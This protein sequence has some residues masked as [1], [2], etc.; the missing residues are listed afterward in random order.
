MS[1]PECAT[2][3]TGDAP[4]LERMRFFP[5]QLITSDDL[6]QEQNYQRARMRR[7]NR[8]LHGWGVVCGA[9]VKP[10]ATSSDD[11]QGNSAEV[12]VDPGYV[13]G[14][15]GDEIVIEAPVTVDVT[16]EDLDGNAV[17]CGGVADP[18][19]ANVRIDRTPGQPLYLAV[20]YAEC[21]TRPVRSHACGCGC[22]DGCEYS[23][24]RDSFVL[25]VLTELPKSHHPMKGKKGD[26]HGVLQCEVDAEG[27]PV[28]RRPCLACP[29]DP[30]VVLAQ[31]SM[32][33]PSAVGTVDCDAHRRYPAAFGPYYYMCGGGTS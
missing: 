11:Q 12:I 3:G 4:Y 30:W 20:K 8:L 27:D 21:Q 29:P 5:G 22:D 6:I 25:K 19:C 2:C 26:L 15:Y 13:L 18:W 16:S 14:P 10:K 32:A 17:P 33:S 28:P 24:I 9:W 7:H 31:I 1:T 23:R